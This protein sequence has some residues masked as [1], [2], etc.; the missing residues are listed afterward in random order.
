MGLRPQISKIKDVRGRIRGYR[1]TL[2]LVEADAPTAQGAIAECERLATEALSYGGVLVMHSL[3]P[4][5]DG[6]RPVWI[7]ERRVGGGWQYR[8][9]RPLRPGSH[10]DGHSSCCFDAPGR[11]EAEDTMRRHWYQCNVE[12]FA[13]LIHSLGALVGAQPHLPPFGKEWSDSEGCYVWSVGTKFRVLDAE[14]LGVDP[15]MVCIVLRADGATMDLEV[16]RLDALVAGVAAHRA[17][18]QVIL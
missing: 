3:F 16:P 13:L 6:E 12:P 1:A 2:G 5:P 17:G 10:Y 14:D 8:I 4:E 11:M 18:L 9:A 7:L 15:G